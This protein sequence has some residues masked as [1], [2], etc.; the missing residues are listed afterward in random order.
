MKKRALFYTGFLVAWF[1]LSTVAYAQ[2]SVITSRSSGE[3]LSAERIKEMFVGRAFIWENGNKVQVVDQERTE[4]R[5]TFYRLFLK[6]SFQ[7]IHTQR[8]RTAYVNKAR[9]PIYAANDEAVRSLVADNPNAIG[10]I[11]TSNLNDSV[12]EILRIDAENGSAIHVG[13]QGKD[14]LK[15]TE[16]SAQ[17]RSEPGRSVSEIERDYQIGLSAYEARKWERAIQSF[18]RVIRVNPEYAQASQLL[19]EAENKRELQTIKAFAGRLYEQAQ[20]AY[21]DGRI[22]DA[23]ELFLKVFE[24]EPEYESTADFLKEIEERKSLERYNA[25]IQEGVRENVE[26]ANSDFVRSEQTP[27]VQSSDNGSSLESNLLS[28][29]KSQINNRAENGELK[30]QSPNESTSFG[31]KGLFTALNLALAALLLVPLFGFLYSSKV[32][33]KY[34]YA[35]GRL[36]HVA[37]IYEKLLAR[38]PG[39]MGYY[40]KLASVYLKLGREDDQAIETY[41]VVLKLKLPVE[42]SE[43]LHSIVTG[44]L[45]SHDETGSEAIS[46]LEDAVKQEFEKKTAEMKKDELLHA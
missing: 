46:I 20:I 10:Y 8:M 5:T 37:H 23:H 7:A 25:S 34:Y 44:Y 1:A 22:D 30:A 11:F 27:A 3:L 43:K 17:Q 33:V 12:H 2:I 26:S 40:S 42:N 14:D 24:I 18:E 36:D 9:N 45:L 38:N 13:A 6:D 29:S 39:K 35:R 15:K 21:V 31:S 41:K 19:K 16:N 4:A 28:D 32:R